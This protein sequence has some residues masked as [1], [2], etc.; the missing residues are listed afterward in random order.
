MR[1]SFANAPRAF[2]LTIA[3]I[4]A[5]IIIAISLGAVKTVGES[6]VMTTRKQADIDTAI[7]RKLIET[8]RQINQQ[9]PVMVDDETRLDTTIVTGKQLCYKFTLVNV[10][11]AQI[12]KVTLRK[13][14]LENFKNNICNNDKA[15]K[16]L[17]LGVSFYYVYSDKSGRIVADEVLSQRD[18]KY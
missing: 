3:S 5:L 1:I 12:N 8:S 13:H 14:L 11:K 15:T 10:S 17:N 16:L 18:C 6:A 4:A 2:I 7:S 9:V